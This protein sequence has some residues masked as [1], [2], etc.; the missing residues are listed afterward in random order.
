MNRARG[1]S[2]VPTFTD[3]LPQPELR[4]YAPG[5][6]VFCEDDPSDG[7][8]YILVEGEVRAFRRGRELETLADA[9]S[10]F[11]EIGLI[12]GLPRSATV[13]AMQPTKAAVI[14][15]ETFRLL[16]L[17]NPSFALEIM[18]LLTRRAR[19]NLI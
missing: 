6:N 10:V 2:A 5:E 15:D 3:M 9:G 11:G 4:A 17:R 16:I 13:R 7:H 12:D 8:L 19:A 14:D 1:N 18:R